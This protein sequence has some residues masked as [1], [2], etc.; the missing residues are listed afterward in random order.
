MT[1]WTWN[2][3]S[4][5]PSF[6]P[7]SSLVEKSC[8]TFLK[9]ILS[10]I[11]L[12]FSSVPICVF[13]HILWPG[14]MITLWFLVLRFQPWFSH[15]VMSPIFNKTVKWGTIA[16]KTLE[17]I[18]FP[19]SLKCNLSIYHGSDWGHSCP[20]QRQHLILKRACNLQQLHALIEY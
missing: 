20:V 4:N 18:W 8:Q 3:G 13:C 19:G 9:R 16:M 14:R 15:S 10:L 2:E 7:G 5:I 11:S 1:R 17:D 12:L 6:T